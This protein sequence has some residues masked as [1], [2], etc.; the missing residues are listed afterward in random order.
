[1]I[2]ITELRNCGVLILLL[3]CCLSVHADDLGMP[4]FRN[5]SSNAYDAHNRNYDVVCDD[6]GTLFVA[7]FEGLLYYNGSNWHKIHTPGISRVTRVAK[8]SRGR[9]WVGGY[10]VFGY[11]YADKNGRLQLKTLVSDKDKDGFLQ[12]VDFIKCTG[13][14]IYVHTT[15][16][17]SYYVKDDNR[18]EVLSKGGE[19]LFS[20]AN[21]SVKA[22]IMPTRSM[23]TYETGLGVSIR[24]SNGSSY[25]LSESDGLISN[26]I[27][28][29]TFDKRQML[30]GATERGL[31]AADMA[32]PF[33]QITELQGLKG[34]VLSINQ[35]GSTTY[36][37]TMDGLFVQR[38]SR[39]TQVADIGLAC[40]QLLKEDANSLL[41]ATSY[42]L[43]R[44]TA[45]GSQRL[46]DGN[47]FSVC[48]AGNGEGI[49]TGETDGIYRLMPGGQRTKIAS[50]EKATKL[51]YYNGTVTAETIFGTQWTI[52]LKDNKAQ[53]TRR[54]A[55][56]NTPKMQYKDCFGSEWT[57]DASG[58][59]LKMKTGQSYKDVF[60]SWLHPLRSRA[61]NTM[62][63]NGKGMVWVGG[64]F[65]V[66]VFDATMLQFLKMQK[67]QRP[68]IR[69]II[70]LRDSVIWG[71]YS[72]N[73]LKP[74][75]EL[76]DIDLPHDCQNIK[77]VFSSMTQ[78]LIAPTYYR[79]RVNDG[80]WSEWTD[81]SVWRDNTINPGKQKIEV[82]AMDAYGN[83]SETSTVEIYVHW[84]WY[85]KWW[86]VLIYIALIIWRITK[87]MQWRTQRLEAEKEKLES[88]VNERTA[89]LSTAYEE[90]R[91]TSA[92]LSE[93]LLDLKRT[94]KD[95]V[96]M[97]R[98]ATA[99]KLTQGLIDRILNPINYINNFSR[100]TT[101]L[102]KDLR[103]DIEDEQENMSEDNY[104]DCEDILDMMTQNLQKIEEHG[105]NTTRTLR[106]MEAM[107]NNGIG[108]L[109]L[110][111]I[112]PLCKQ[113]ITAIKANYTADIE[114]HGISV[115]AVVPEHDVMVAIDFEAMTRVLL[116]VM[117]NSVYAIIKKA[118]AAPYPGEL[119]L[120]LTDSDK[121]VRIAIRDNGIGI[122][123]GIK[124]KVFDPFFTTKPTGE[125][126]GVGLYLVREV[127]N[128]HGGTITM[129][130]EKDAYCEFTITLPK[131]NA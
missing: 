70:S 39:V 122:E 83:V 71:G 130:S 57:T 56:N 52:S 23:V 24:H 129:Q 127:V 118:K 55:A 54:Q 37:G 131:A 99:G 81:E 66:I 86:M 87:F 91:K 96:R 20:M 48:K 16:G 107:L 19:Q 85:L 95:L 112:T 61:I 7:N 82:Q 117:A 93:T 2:R 25:I 12:E 125:A 77:I 110:Q 53:C 14:R 30:W 109:T 45:G 98:T 40:W 22:L 9:I 27:N 72:E 44:I 124:E 58:Y 33:S 113:A 102:A 62:H 4:F 15:T 38:G 28:F 119:T 67:V 94:Q 106:A 47:T 36:F 31:F 103:E 111:N 10:N 115:S 88:I 90:Q 43:F 101:G 17:K 116:S 126:S 100:L 8:D 65:G 97:E 26:A 121:D 105:V 63:V 6:Y 18:L 120:T 60:N 41:A 64:D 21:D 32:S 59:D 89:E 46:S 78:S 29:I 35:I 114:K 128:D 11:V 74:V 51:S 84:P 92:E 75:C 49:I 108:A 13:N 42:G 5:Y 69:E 1:M 68:Y 50:I 104:E 76:K 123:D 73:T 80:E 79:Y 3:L 34:E